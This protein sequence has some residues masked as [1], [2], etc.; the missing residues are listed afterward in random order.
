MGIEV[1][2]LRT[3]VCL[4]FVAAAVKRFVIRGVRLEGLVQAARMHPFIQV[5]LECAL[6]LLVGMVASMFVA[7]FCVVPFKRYN[8]WAVIWSVALVIVAWRAISCP[9]MPVHLNRL[10]LIGLAALG[11]L[12]GMI[13]TV[14]MLHPV[15][16][17]RS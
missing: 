7:F 11:V 5:C 1:T 8:W 10:V 15:C 3:L 12:T 14:K 9:E 17:S 16:S 6:A 13:G 2:L 4:E